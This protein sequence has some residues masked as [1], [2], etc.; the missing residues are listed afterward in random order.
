METSD[1]SSIILDESPNGNSDL[2]PN[3]EWVTLS[4]DSSR[5][6]ARAVSDQ[7]M[8]ELSQQDL[9]GV[10]GDEDVSI[11]GKIHEPSRR[12]FWK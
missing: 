11:T 3:G 9:R 7:S 8:T 10:N 12:I 1:L 4:T 5:V 2:G 6:A